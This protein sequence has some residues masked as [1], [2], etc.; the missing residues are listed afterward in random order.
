MSDYRGHGPAPSNVERPAPSKVEGARRAILC[1]LDDTLFDHSWATR[2]ALARV[3]AGDPAC[4]DW[5]LDEV[6]RRHGEI[7]D[8]IHPEVLSGR[9]TLDRARIDR[10][11]QLLGEFNGDATEARAASWATAYRSAYEVDW[12]PVPG[13]VALLQAARAAGLPVVVVT[14]NLRREQQ[15]KLDRCGLTAHVTALVTS[16]EVGVPKP[17]AAIFSAALK[18]AGVPASDAAMLGDAWDADIAGARAAGIYAL[19]FNRRGLPSRDAAIAEVR[20]LEP[21][22]EVLARLVG[23]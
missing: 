11:L 13:A 20:S 10:F 21:A 12:R 2:Q 19:W 7:L 5:P 4:R 1:D 9:R 22:D 14:N 23:E 17:A 8:A 18:A 16:E 3:V 15:L 6:E